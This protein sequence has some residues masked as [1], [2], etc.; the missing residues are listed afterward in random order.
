MFKALEKLKPQEWKPLNTGIY[1]REMFKKHL[2]RQ[3][4]LLEKKRPVGW[5]WSFHPAEL[6]YV[7][8][9]INIFP[10]Q[11]SAYCAAK[12]LSMPLIDS[13]VEKGYAGFLC[14]YFKCS[15]GSIFN[16]EDAPLKGHCGLKPSFVLDSRML[17]YGHHTMSEVFSEI[18]GIPR[19]VL[20][21]P[22]WV[23]DKVKNIDELTKIPEKVDEYYL[24]FVIQQIKDY[25]GFLE[26]LTGE[27]MDEEK[28]KNVFKISEET[29]KNLLRIA[30]LMFSKPTPG[31]QIDVGDYVMVGF[32]LHGA[33]Y[34][35]EFVKKSREV[36]E[37]K[38]KRKMGVV[39]DEKLRL[40]THGIMP[41]HALPLYK[42]YE[43]LGIT[44]PVNPYLQASMCLVEA[45]KP[46][47]SMARR[48]LNG[49]NCEIEIW[50]ES[51]LRN[52][53]KADVDG[54]IMFE[55]T[56]C[57]VIAMGLRVLKDI[58]YEELGIPSL[59]IEGPQ[60]DPRGMPFERAKTQIDA[61]IESLL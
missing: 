15:V 22:Y 53:K 13:F 50:G 3:Q 37:D 61:F 41:W 58:L 43:E 28:F 25:V 51:M 24:D 27:K 46:F 19:Y 49:A 5:F 56:G 30:E 4:K 40:I 2:T 39:A 59:I 1:F 57:R 38:V 60:C 10:E 14:D 21:A 17:C 55:N 16:P 54:A 42:Y 33:D 11:Y 32:F 8:D 26:K 6:S 20:D 29:S 18:Y 31:S 36:I 48:C 47:E 45:S 52:V 44:F 12:G 34:A 9:I 7:F 35:L 23:K